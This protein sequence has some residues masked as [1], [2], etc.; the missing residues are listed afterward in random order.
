MIKDIE[1]EISY[2]IGL[3]TEGSYWDFKRKMA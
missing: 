1:D 2:L 3:K